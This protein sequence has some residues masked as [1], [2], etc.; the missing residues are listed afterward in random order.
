MCNLYRLRTTS[1][2]IRHV[3]GADVPEGAN[4]GTE[5]YPG[6]PGL[7]TA[8]D[9]ARVMNWGFPR[10][11]T[12]K[13]GQQL[14]PRPVTNARDD[15]LGS[16]FWK[17]S[18]E[19][20]RCLVP[21]TQWAEPQGED[22][23]KTRTWYSVAGD[24]PFAVAGMWIPTDIWGKCYTMV[25]VASCEQMVDVHDRMP[26]ILRREDW[27]TWVTGTPEAAFSLCRTWDE[28][29]KVAQTPELWAHKAGS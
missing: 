9:Q 3:F 27:N 16:R 28:E 20:R 10:V 24:E 11:G 15:N 4:Y 6:Y 19:K 13:N 8:G 29:L 21:L 14:K 22:G 17:A 1:A 5:V 7:V 12:G 18:F 26:V 2:E 23:K 25:M